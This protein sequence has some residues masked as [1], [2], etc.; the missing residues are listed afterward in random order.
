[1][2]SIIFGTHNRLVKLKRAI[3]SINEASKLLAKPAEVIVVDGGST[4][5]TLEFLKNQQIKV[6]AEGS[7]HGVTRAYNRGFRLASE[8]YITWFSDDFLYVRDALKIAIDRLAKEN[9]NTLIS[10]SIDVKDGKGF[11]NYGGNT[12]IGAAHRDLF[13]AVDYWSEDF[14]TYASDNDFSQ[15]IEWPV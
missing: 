15:K 11:K 14:I 3:N 8:N 9:N 10:F 2:I 1:M 5:G 4:D 7:L 13:E 6:I 12:P